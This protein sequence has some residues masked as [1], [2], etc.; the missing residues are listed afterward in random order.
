MPE[1]RRHQGWRV[2]LHR[3]P[4]LPAPA[5]RPE[6][7]RLDEVQG[8]AHGRLVRA[9]RPCRP[10]TAQQRL[11]RY[12]L[13]RRQRDVQPRAV[14]VRAVPQ[15]PQ[16]DVRARNVSLE[17]AAE[18][19]RLDMAPQIQRRRAAA[20]PPACL[21]VLVAFPGVVVLAVIVRRLAETVPLAAEIMHRRG[22]RGEIEHRR[23][24]RLNLAHR[25]QPRMR[26]LG[27][28]AGLGAAGNPGLLASGSSSWHAGHV[29]RRAAHGQRGSRQVAACSGGLVRMELARFRTATAC[30]RLTVG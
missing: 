3:A 11:Q 8:R 15:P 25:T 5:P 16:P 20:A 13:R 27:A 23:D 4:L 7:P 24:H 2:H 19:S 6:Q 17:H 18:L 26:G 21:A 28:D 14:L 1:G 12:R 29:A 9:H 10:R 22:R 30:S